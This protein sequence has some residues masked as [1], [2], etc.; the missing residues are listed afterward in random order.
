MKTSP[1]GVDGDV[2]GVVEGAE[3]GGEADRA[4]EAEAGDAGAGDAADDPGRGDLA[5]HVVAAVGDEDVALGVDGGAAGVVE[6]RAGGL[7]AVAVLAEG[8]Q[9]PGERGGG[10]AGDWRRSRWRRCRTRTRCRR[11]R[12]RRPGGTGCRRGRWRCRSGSAGPG[13]WRRSRR[14]RRSRPARRPRPRPGRPRRSGRADDAVSGNP[15]SQL[16]RSW[17]ALLYLAGRGDRARPLGIDNRGASPAKVNTRQGTRAA[18]TRLIHR[19]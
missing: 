11:R 10:A 2:L 17:V 14:P 16:C 12:R 8:G 7:A 18:H 6:R 1:C 4:G 19:D 3:R 15:S 9:R 13:R 5:D